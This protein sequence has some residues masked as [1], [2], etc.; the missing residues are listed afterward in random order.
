L[1]F[2]N[3]S[4]GIFVNGELQA[5]SIQSRFPRA[6]RWVT[7]G[8]GAREEIRL[9]REFEYVKD[10]A[11]LVFEADSGFIA[12]QATFRRPGAR[13]S[14]VF[15]GSLSR[16]ELLTM[17]SGGTT[18]IVLINLDSL[19]NT[20]S[21]TAHDDAGAQTAGAEV[22]V[23][24]GATTMGTAAQLLGAD[25]GSATQMRFS[26]NRRLLAFVL[27]PSGDGKSIE[28]LSA[29]AEYSR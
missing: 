1:T 26:S 8:P 24:A 14:L 18:G 5:Y 15:G 27:T 2:F 16:G 21:L 17:E 22:R 28:A 9:G 25:P 6:R 4:G 7:L 29:L 10:I 13:A 3:T 19:A 23:R 20:V 12:S 11:Y